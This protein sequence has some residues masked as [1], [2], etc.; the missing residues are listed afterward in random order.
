MKIQN[1]EKTARRA[2]HI[3]ASIGVHTT[4]IVVRRIDAN[5]LQQLQLA[6]QG[7]GRQGT[8]N[9]PPLQQADI[10]VNTR[11]I[12][13]PNPRSLYMLWDEYMTGIGHNKPAKFFTRAERG[14]CKYKYSRR[15]IVWDVVERLVRAG[16]PSRD[17][18]D[19]I[20][21]QYGPNLSPT[22]IINILRKDKKNLPPM[23]RA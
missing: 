7:R 9:A 16:V 4:V 2:G 23:L 8:R 17:S 5:P 20:Y 13:T 21:T 1:V 22:A 19:R 10:N 12:L 11:A 18:I 15:K 14:R 6:A 3:M